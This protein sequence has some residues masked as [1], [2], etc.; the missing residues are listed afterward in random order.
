MKF[1]TFQSVCA[2]FGCVL[3]ASVLLYGVVQLS[4][5]LQDFS[6]EMSRYEA[7]MASGM[8]R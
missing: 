7:W 1:S 2:V 8:S 6:S 3:V 5:L 4:E